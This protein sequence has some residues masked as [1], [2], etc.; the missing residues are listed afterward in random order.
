MTRGILRTFDND[1]LLCLQSWTQALQ[2]RLYSILPFLLINMLISSRFFLLILDMLF[3]SL[4]KCDFG[5]HFYGL[6]RLQGMKKTKPILLGSAHVK[7]PCLAKNRKN[8][9]NGNTLNQLLQKVVIAKTSTGNSTGNHLHF[10]V[11][12]NGVVSDPTIYF[13]AQ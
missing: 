6:F 11:Y 5:C 2:S 7:M 9:C 1:L 4:I 3:F 13:A 8:T 10:T 12:K